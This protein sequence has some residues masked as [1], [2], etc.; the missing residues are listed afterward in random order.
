[1]VNRRQAKALLSSK[2]LLTTWRKTRRWLLWVWHEA[3]KM[4]REFDMKKPVH[5]VMVGLLMGTIVAPVASWVYLN[6]QYRL[7][8]AVK[9]VAEKPSPLLKSKL[10]HDSAK[11]ASI[12][13]AEGAEATKDDAKDKLQSRLGGGAKK[14]NQL[15]TATMPDDPQKGIEI[16]DNVSGVSFK[17]VPQMR[18]L[19]GRSKDGQVVYPLKDHSGHMIFTPKANGIKEDIVLNHA[20]ASDVAEFKYGLDLPSSLEAKL[21]DDGSLGFYTG[22]PEL[23]GNISYGS[24][25]DREAVEKARAN[26]QKTY[27]M[28][29]IPAPVIVE[30]GKPT[31]VAARF[32]LDKNILTVRTTGLKKANYPL[33][34]DPTFYITSTTDFILGS[35]DDNIDL[36]VSGQ[37]GRAALGGGSINLWTPDDA[38]GLV[39]PSGASSGQFSAALVAYN[40]YMYIMGGG[41]D[42]AACNS[43]STRTS[44]NVMRISLD[45]NTGALGTTAPTVWTATSSLVTARQGLIGFGY[46]GY[47][48]AV[49]GEDDN[50]DPIPAGNSVEYAKINSDGSVGTWQ[51]TGDLNVS[52]SY[53]AGAIYQGVLYAMGGSGGNLN[54]TLR[55]TIEWARINGDGTITSWN[56][57]T[58]TATGNLGS[59][60]NRFKGAAYNGYVYIT[61]G[62]TGTP[63]VLNTTE[64]AAIQSDGSLGAW[65]STTSFP[66]T[67]RD[68]GMGVNNGYLYVYAGCNRS[69]MDCST[70]GTE[71]LPDTYY[72]AI[73]AD[74][75]IGQWQ[76]TLQYN[77]DSGGSD[78]FAR[79]PGGTTFYS[80]HLYF[81]GGCYN[82]DVSTTND[83][84]T[85]NTGTFIATL[86]SVGRFDRGI[87]TTGSPP[88]S[89][90]STVARM[91]AKAVALNGYMYYIGG[92]SVRGC[93]TYDSTVE[94][95]A[96]NADGTLSNLG[97]T[98]VLSAGAGN[99]AG[100][101]GHTLAAYNDKIY[102]IGGT[103]RTT[104]AGP[105]ATPAT[106]APTATTFGTNATTH[107]VL[108][109]PTINAGD[110]LITLFANDG[111][112][113]VTTPA[114]WTLLST[115]ARGTAARGS[116]Y[117]KV[118]VGN[119]DATNVNF[120]TSASEQG[121]AQVYRVTGWSGDI[122][123]V[124]ADVVDPGAATANPDPPSLTTGWG[125]TNT[126]WLAYSAGSRYAAV[127]TYPTNYT[128]GVISIGGTDTTGASVA[129]ARRNLAAATENPGSFTMSTSQDGVAFTIAVQPALANADSYMS[130]ILS[131][132]QASNGTLGS[133]AAETNGLT[134][135]CAARAFHTTEVWHNYIYVIGGLTSGGAASGNVYYSQIG[136]GGAL[137]TCAL[138]TTTI[139]ARWGHSGGVWGNWM[140]VV[141]GQ[142]DTA[143]TYLG[144]TAGANAV[145]R[146]T[147]NTSSGDISAVSGFAVDVARRLAGGYVDRG[148]LYSFGGDLSGGTA[149]EN[150]ISRAPL[151]SATGAVG[152]F[153]AANIG[154]IPDN[155]PT[156]AVMGVATPR[157]ATAAVIHD[158]YSYVLGGCESDIADTSFKGCS[159]NVPTGDT[160]ELFLP[161]NGGTGQ[162]GT[163]TTGST[164]IVNLPTVSG[165]AGRADHSAVAYNGKLYIVG[166]CRLYTAGSCT[167]GLGDIQRADIETDGTVT[168]SW[169]AMTSLPS[170]EVRSGLRAVAYNGHLYVI[171]GRNSGGT[172]TNTVWFTTIDNTGDL[173]ASWTSADL[174]SG[175]ERADFGAAITNGYLYVVGGINAASTR[176]T[177]VYYASID[178][179]TGAVGTWNTTTAFTT[180]R[181]DFG[182]TAYNGVLYIAG[183]YDGTNTLKDVQYADLAS[184]GTISAWI[185]TTDI[186][187]G[188]RARQIVGANG[189]LYY[190]G[191]ESASNTNAQYATISS[192]GALGSIQKSPTTMSGAH[193]HGAAVFYGGYIYITGGCTL[194]SNV[195]STVSAA[196]DKVGQQAIPRTGHYSKLFDTQVDTTP[197]QLVVNG[198]VG[199]SGKGP[200]GLVEFRFQTASSLDP[201]LGVP[202]L[203]R[204]VVD[205][206]YYNVESLNSSGAFVGQAF[207][208]QYLIAIDDS[209]AGTFPD[210]PK[211]S[212]SQ[213]S[214]QDVTLF[215]HANPSRRLRHGKSFTDDACND[216]PAEG[217]ILD[218]AP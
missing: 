75:T 5:V 208:Y 10:K 73:N 76:R 29:K 25:K 87:A 38:P 210:V 46:N 7:T 137:G 85:R 153:S 177:S 100:R 161:N 209:R 99:G 82:E 26:A 101:L 145:Q 155:A 215:Y 119:E 175:Q 58:S 78:F 134:G 64:F 77:Y 194:S 69:S 32:A 42:A 140:Y 8:S 164:N 110:L 135:S 126:L 22:T 94:Y 116:V 23:F 105:T 65:V 74:G 108:M 3:K 62:L 163:F 57:S 68:H 141:G 89:G 183:G 33:S 211:A 191:D 138:A 167:T 187:Q 121:A 34:I 212:Y 2:T 142:S 98:T 102:V 41:C 148:I 162:L 132:T 18:L 160:T 67:R 203:I 157:S 123:G 172:P 50:E 83:C 106:A 79:V 173:G 17:F 66:I 1:V 24:D 31:K 114:G 112:A 168:S 39:D 217:C 185:P 28:F 52:R 156:A 14:T 150:D 182:F 171:G 43:L 80:N 72:A 12:F 165:T 11:K 136:S 218:T 181:T 204:P 111:S 196:N 92:C 213:T 184:N 35:I 129:S 113:T 169:T 4:P 190:L 16:S 197:T 130:T 107:N 47:L 180:A 188:A 118:A 146:L 96:I 149:A 159:A 44:N 93:D 81:I 147:I 45:P 186:S 216:I 97:T 122:S 120:V 84:A 174:P 27:L 88:Y 179:L 139:Q 198:A 205:G 117:G 91:G 176:Q 144:I 192:M 206:R 151:D 109:P 189:Y 36:S 202:Q 103:E 124:A 56:L 49:G 21:D 63:S 61:G 48:Y 158:G 6:E 90:T 128:N 30:T 59:A 15:Y 55:N 37:I 166:G 143:G 125:A 200:G 154:N 13:N 20:P 9:A 127:T 95:A 133:W 195:C 207:Q 40:G 60:R 199:G 71:L 193:A 53:P 54:T 170:S 104:G 19:D 115:G 178:D 51:N 201:V 152:T 70:Q 214:V 131:S 86:D